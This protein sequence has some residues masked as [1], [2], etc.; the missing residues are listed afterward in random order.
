MMSPIGDLNETNE[1]WE[2]NTLKNEIKSMVRPLVEL[3]F[4]KIKADK[5]LR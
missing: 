4:A 5:Y 1:L 3:V 2:F